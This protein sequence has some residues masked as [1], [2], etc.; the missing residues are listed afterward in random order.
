MIY[1]DFVWSYSYKLLYADDK[2]SKLVNTY[3]GEYAVYN[4]FNNIIKQTKYCIEVM[5]I[6]YIKKV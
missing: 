1:A 2:F 6:W 4:F 5:T 3:L